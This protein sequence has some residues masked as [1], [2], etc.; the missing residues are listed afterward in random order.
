RSPSVQ[1]LESHLGQ[2]T[3]VAVDPAPAAPG[4]DGGRDRLASTAS[5]AT[6]AQT[7]GN[8]RSDGKVI[9]CYV[10]SVAPDA[11]RT[12]LWLRLCDGEGFCEALLPPPTLQHMLGQGDM[13]T[14]AGRAR[15]LHGLF[16]L[17][18]QG[19]TFHIESFSRG[20]TPQELEQQLARA[21]APAN[22]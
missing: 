6:D 15:L 2:S 17:V 8:S 18:Q 9:R 1:E 20:P 12:S 13:E 4:R 14:L 7:A 22:V 19:E 21:G 3:V 11:G 5:A 10:A 16:R